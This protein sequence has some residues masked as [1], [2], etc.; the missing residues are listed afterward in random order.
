MCY[1]TKLRN[2]V[3]QPRLEPA[4]VDFWE[5]RNFRARP[6]HD[7][8]QIS[9]SDGLSRTSC[10]HP[11]LTARFFFPDVVRGPHS[12]ASGVKPVVRRTQLIDAPLPLPTTTRS[13]LTVARGGHYFVIRDH[14]GL[15]VYRCVDAERIWELKTHGL[16]N[17][18]RCHP[19]WEMQEGGHEMVVVFQEYEPHKAFGTLRVCRVNLRTGIETLELSTPIA[20]HTSSITYDPVLCGSYVVVQ[21]HHRGMQS[22][23]FLVVDWRQRVFAIIHAF[24]GD[25]H[26]SAVQL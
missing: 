18:Y 24:G 3:P 21:T 13:Q 12:W 8:K 11:E 4:A 22:L 7:F 23:D 5:Q 15:R 9:S 19:E 16:G 6:K 2:S 1:E 25:L 20:R 26:V 17:L 10:T 14:F